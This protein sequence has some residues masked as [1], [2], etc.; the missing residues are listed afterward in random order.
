MG[1]EDGDG[2]VGFFM[3]RFLKGSRF[4]INKHSFRALFSPASNLSPDSYIY[5]YF[6]YLFEWGEYPTKTCT[7]G[8][9]QHID[10]IPQAFLI[11]GIPGMIL[12]ESSDAGAEALSAQIQKALATKKKK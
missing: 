7:T 1:T 2:G 6:P 4:S 12:A 8:C 5:R 3:A 9:I 11:D 10:S